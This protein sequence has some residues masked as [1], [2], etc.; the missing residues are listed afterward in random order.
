VRRSGLNIAHTC[1]TLFL[2]TGLLI[3]SSCAA[4]TSEGPPGKSQAQLNYEN[5]LCAAR[6]SSVEIPYAQCMLHFGNT[7]HLPDGRTLTP[8]QQYES[9]YASPSPPPAN[10]CS[11]FAR[12]SPQLFSQCMEFEQFNYRFDSEEYCAKATNKQET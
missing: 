8:S 9:Q 10:T 12:G 6:T 11:N 2:I 1:P 4:V 3:L 7:V 5:A